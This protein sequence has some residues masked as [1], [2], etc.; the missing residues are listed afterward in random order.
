MSKLIHLMLLPVLVVSLQLSAARA[1]EACDCPGDKVIFGLYET[2]TLE[3]I[4]QLKVSTLI[5]TGATTTSLDARNIK[6]YVNRKGRR[7]V[8]YDFY[9]KPSG[10]T[11]SM[12]QPVSR[13]ARVITHS[14]SPKERAVV[15][16][17]ISIGSTRHLLETSLINRGNFP[18][19]LLIG[20]NYLKKSGLVD[21]A[22]SY[23]QSRK[24]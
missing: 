14:G 7:W 2:A 10:K 20:R 1:A 8:Y 4:Q 3:D 5:D 19:Q 16:N 15:R 18:Q 12:H 22:R 6:M 17:T 13:V 21:S 23:L 9:H 11:V 24:Q